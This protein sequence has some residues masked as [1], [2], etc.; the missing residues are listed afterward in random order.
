MSRLAKLGVGCRPFFCPMHQQPVLRR[1]GLFE[2]E[3]YPV[4]ERMYCRGFYVPSGLG[5]SNDQI[6]RVAQSLFNVMK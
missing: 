3:R 2:G 5:L 4:A 1:L 6:E